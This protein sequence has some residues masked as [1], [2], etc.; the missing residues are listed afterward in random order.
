MFAGHPGPSPALICAS[1]RTDIP[2]FFAD[3][4]HRRRAAGSVEFE[5]VFGVRGKVSLAPDDVLGYLFWTR[6]PT[7]FLG[8]LEQLRAEHVP[9]AFQFTL[10][11]YGR[12]LEPNRPPL[13]GAVRSFLEVSLALPG[14]GAIEWR[15]DPIVLSQ[16]YPSGFHRDTFGRIAE[17]LRGAT[18]VVNCSLVEPYLHAVRRVG[19]PTVA[20]R[21]PDPGRHEAVRRRFPELGFAGDG[22]RELAQQLA[23]ISHANGIELRACANA[24]L[25]LDSS[26]CCGLGLFECYGPEVMECMTA[27]RPAPSRPGCRCLRAVDIGMKDTCRGGCRYCYVV[28][29]DRAVREHAAR[30]DPDSVSLR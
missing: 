11:G 29:S 5:N 28:G 9:Y 17:T 2:R 16:T 24:T 12:E 8:E 13:E 20:Y 14:P 23:E 7:P 26:Q 3:W 25:G 10:T 30:Y 4:F 22:A 1:R 21:P 15:Y 19:D 18:R 6:D 27:L